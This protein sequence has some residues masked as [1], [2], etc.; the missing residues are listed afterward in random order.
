MNWNRRT[1]IWVGLALLVLTNAVALGGVAYNRSGEPDAVLKLGERELNPP[2][3][4]NDKGENS[5]LSLKLQWRSPPPAAPTQRGKFFYRGDHNPGW[6]NAQKM[7]ELGFDADATSKPQLFDA[8]PSSRHRALPRDVFIVLEFNGPA[9]QD[10]V[11]RAQAAVDAAPAESAPTG[12]V[13]RKEQAKVELAAQLVDTRLFAVD[14]GLERSALRA[15]YPD[16]SMYAV[17]RGRI[18]PMRDRTEDDLGGFIDELSVDEINVPLDMRP[19][20]EGVVARNGYD[21][22]VPAVHFD[23]T[24]MFGQRAEPWLAS[25]ARSHAAAIHP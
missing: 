17:V 2:Y 4:W 7:R 5:G 16:R 1:A 23:A 14:A 25:A 9:Y 11:R 21:R 22:S 8:N 13:S 10:S 3:V 19:V 6:L 15:R 12:V 24:V 18:S 20:F